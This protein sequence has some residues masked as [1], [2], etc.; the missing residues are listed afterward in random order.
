[1]NGIRWKKKNKTV[2]ENTKRKLKVSTSQSS[3][4][5]FHVIIFLCRNQSQIKSFTLI[6]V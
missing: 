3:L 6:N 5:L 4:L 2:N 1:M